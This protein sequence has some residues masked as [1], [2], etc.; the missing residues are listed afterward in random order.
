MSIDD[1]RSTNRVAPYVNSVGW[2]YEILL[3]PNREFARAL[4]V[5]NVPH[6]H[7]RH[8]RQRGLVTQQLR[9]RRRIRTV[10][11]TH[12]AGR[13]SA[14]SVRRAGGW[15]HSAHQPAPR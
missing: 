6:L 8:G 11:G 9:G 3:D 12:Q 15:Y 13:M 14:I 5:N 2:E 1:M 10:R 4:N 7:R